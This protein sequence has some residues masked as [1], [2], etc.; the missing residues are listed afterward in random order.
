LFVRQFDLDAAGDIWLLL[1]M[2]QSIQCGQGLESTEE[3][4]VLL[5][6]S[7][8]ARAIQQNRPIGLA[9]Y[10]QTPQIISTNSGGGQQ[11]RILR[12]LAYMHADGT[13]SLAAAL[14][15]L[16]KIAKRGSA[17]III[18]ASPE[19]NWIPELL[20]LA[21]RG[22]ESNVILLDRPSFG[23]VGVSQGQQD[24]IRHLG[25]NCQMFY[26]G[27]INTQLPESNEKSKIK[28]TPFGK[29]VMVED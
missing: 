28:I 8:S 3:Y 7:I 29:A 20:H 21:Q 4:A 9:S 18:S 1:D 14:L 22:I 16:G 25:I 17:V 11:W 2:E 5:A 15:D 6:A 27:E 12:A 26:Q 13:A 24:A 19:S 10:G 23:G